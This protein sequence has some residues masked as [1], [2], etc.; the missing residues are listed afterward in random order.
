MIYADE[1]LYLYSEQGVV[2]LADASPTG[3]RERGRFT[4]KQTGPPTW[5]HPIITSGRLI[6]RDQDNVYAYDVRAK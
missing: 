3:Y 6:I 4:I 5:S 2:G 1:R